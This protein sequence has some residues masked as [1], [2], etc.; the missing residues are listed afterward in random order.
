[1]R[2]GQSNKVRITASAPSAASATDNAVRLK[3]LRHKENERRTAA[4]ADSRTTL[5]ADGKRHSADG[6]V[7]PFKPDGFD[8]ARD[9]ANRRR[10][11]DSD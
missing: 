7:V 11:D 9:A 3:P 4:D 8:Y 1:V 6:G 5:S 10:R 2:K